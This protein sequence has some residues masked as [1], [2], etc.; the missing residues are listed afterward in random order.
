M[1]HTN[2]SVDKR[3]KIEFHGFHGFGFMVWFHGV[4]VVEAGVL[5]PEMVPQIHYWLCK[6]S[7]H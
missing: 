6:H 3:K 1:I 4:R 7:T 2:L 5:Y